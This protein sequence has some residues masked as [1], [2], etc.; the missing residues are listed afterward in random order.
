MDV[1]IN[2]IHAPVLTHYTALTYTALCK[3]IT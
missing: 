2:A 3:S 1:L